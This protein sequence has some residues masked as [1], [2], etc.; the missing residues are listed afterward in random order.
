MSATQIAKDRRLAGVTTALAR[1]TQ[2]ITADCL[3]THFLSTRQA[4]F[5]ARIVRPS[6][7]E[8]HENQQLALRKINASRASGLLKE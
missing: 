6:D 5:D 8:N 2:T 4:L 1:V 3:I 7:V